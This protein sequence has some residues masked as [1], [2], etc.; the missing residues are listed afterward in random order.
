M[1][2]LRILHVAE[3]KEPLGFPVQLPYLVQFLFG[4][5]SFRHSSRQHV[6]Q[7]TQAVP[8]LRLPHGHPLLCTGY[9][10]S[11]IVRA[12]MAGSTGCH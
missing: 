8:D 10:G 9:Q 6:F 7:F 4:H 1:R 5:L 3:I 12:A 11:G 2:A